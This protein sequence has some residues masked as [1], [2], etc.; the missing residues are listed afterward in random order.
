MTPPGLGCQREGAKAAQTKGPKHPGHPVL[1]HG[2]KPE[3]SMGWAKQ[4]KPR[5]LS[6]QEA[7][8]SS[9]D[10]ALCG[11]ENGKESL[12][13]DGAAVCHGQDS[14]HPGKRQERQYHAGT[15]E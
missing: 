9:D 3:P 2:E 5:H 4:E 8:H 6:A 10:K 15:P 13:E 7:V 14:G 12:E 1:H 11:V